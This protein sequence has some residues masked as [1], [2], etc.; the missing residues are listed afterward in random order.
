MSLSAPVPGSRA[1][2][3]IPWEQAELQSNGLYAHNME[4]L[5][6]KYPQLS[7]MELRVCALVKA[8]LPSREIARILFIDE[9]TVENHRTS[10]RRKI[11]VRKGKTLLTYLAE[12]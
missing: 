4:A 11:N 10:S 5:A 7:P 8:M 6:T 9:R 2:R 1:K 3:H 12:V